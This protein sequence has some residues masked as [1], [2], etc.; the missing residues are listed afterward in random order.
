M[1]T[2][3]KIEARQLKPQLVFFRSLPTRHHR[4]LG[5]PGVTGASETYDWQ[6]PGA[7]Q[8]AAGALRH[9]PL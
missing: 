6:R 3:R 1:I 2:L 5:L 7:N 9:A 8:I 4:L